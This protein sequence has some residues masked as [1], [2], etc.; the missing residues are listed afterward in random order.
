VTSQN[1]FRVTLQLLPA[2]DR[3]LIAGQLVGRR[4]GD[5]WFAALQAAQLLEDLRIPYDRRSASRDLRR[6]EA[7]EFVLSRAAAPQWSLTPLGADHVNDV[8]GDIDLD[9]LTPAVVLSQGAELGHVLHRPLDPALAPARWRDAIGR[10]L[11]TS[12]FEQN[13]FLMTRFPRDAAD[14]SFLDPVAEVIDEI[15][16]VLARRGLSVH[17]A[18]D[19]QIDDDLYSNIAGYMW[20]CQYGIGLFEELDEPGLNQN[21]L[22]EVGSML[23]LGRRCALLRDPSVERWP[24]DFVGQIYK[25]VRFADTAA[26]RSTVQDWADLDLGLGS[27]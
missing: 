19:R 23:V 18:S 14:T 20:A 15:R 12:P 2:R 1:E 24:T 6:L 26:V 3:L 11:T 27:R 10:L 17:L 16:A 4:N 22:V 21:L 13:V 25:P 5:G 8:I 9:Q 7:S